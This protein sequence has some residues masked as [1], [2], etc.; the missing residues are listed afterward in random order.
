MNELQKAKQELEKAIRQAEEVNREVE[1]NFLGKTL[2]NMETIY[3]LTPK[4]KILKTLFEK[5]EL[6]P[7]LCWALAEMVVKGLEE[8][9]EITDKPDITP[10]DIINE[11]D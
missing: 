3:Q 10:E 9:Y 4:G 1:K 8:D 7:E 5:T 11:K 2:N 6:D